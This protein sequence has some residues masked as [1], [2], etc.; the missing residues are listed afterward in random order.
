MY[1]AM[2][3]MCAIVSEITGMHQGLLK[4]LPFESL[5]NFKRQFKVL[6]M[7]FKGLRK[8]FKTGF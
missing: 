1:N 5:Q 7:V 3:V 6:A 2:L 8:A 4:G